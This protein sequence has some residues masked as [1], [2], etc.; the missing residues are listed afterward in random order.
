MIM[1]FR[2]HVLKGSTL[3]LGA[4]SFWAAQMLTI[5]VDITATPYSL[6]V[7]KVIEASPKCCWTTV[8]KSMPLA[9]TTTLY[10][11]LYALK[12]I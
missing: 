9:D 8:P 7:P 2:R 4:S 11:K 1:L 5:E 10:S 6:H 3:L 12:D